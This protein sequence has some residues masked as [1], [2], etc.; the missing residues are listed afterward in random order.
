M[1][2]FIMR[3]LGQGV[4]VLILVTMFVFIVMNLLP[5]DPITIYLSQSESS[6]MNPE[7][8]AM[9]KHQYGLDKPVP[10]QYLNWIGGVVKGNLGHSIIL[11]QPVTQLIGKRFPVTLHIGIVVFILSGLLG[12]FFGVI[13]ALKRGTWIDSVL[14]VLANIGITAPS[15]LV[16]ILLIY[17]LGYKLSWLP[18]HGYT[19]PLEDFWMSTKQIIMPAFCL[20]LAPIAILTRQTRSSMLEVI[21]QDYVRTAWSKG[22]QERT[23]VLRHALKNSFIPII[24]ILGLQ[25]RNI[26]GGSVIIEI[27]FSIPGIG[28]MLVDGVLGQDFQ[29]VQ[30]GVLLIGAAVLI[31]NIFVDIAYGWFDPRIRYA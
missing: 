27:V 12:I 20:A 6:Q 8:I 31:V 9:L 17:F 30:G 2:N 19:S 16:G 10:V 11:D 7:R 28:G 22:L 25:V 3:R 21:R 14:T 15:F 26:V 5:S 29:V 18:L 23:V 24:T 1:S 13:C 4:V